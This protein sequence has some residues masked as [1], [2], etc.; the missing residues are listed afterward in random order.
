MRILLINNQHYLKGG[1]HAVYFNTAK[2]LR[3]KGHEV[4]F[5][6]MKDDNMIE[7]EYSS[8]FPKLIDYNKLSL[9]SKII[10]AKSFLYNKEA[11]CKIKNYVK[12]I[13]PDIAHVHLF[14]GGLTVSIL[15]ALKECNIPVIHTVHDYRLIC[16]AYTFLDRNNEICEKCHDGH[17]IR[18][19]YKKCSLEKKILPS[20]ILSFDAYFRKY[21]HSPLKYI[22]KF[23]F[24]SKFSKNIH[25]SFNKEYMKNSTVLYNFNPNKIG[26]SVPLK[27]KYLLY[28]GRLSREKGIEML[29]E[30]A[31]DLK[32][33]LKIAG[34]GPLYSK[35]LKSTEQNTNIEILGFKSGKD[36][37]QLIQG[38]SYVC[39]PSEWYENNPLSII[40][41]FSLGKPVIGSKIGGIPELLENKRGFLFNVKDYES[42]KNTINIALN[43]S[44]SE[45][46]KYSENVLNFAKNV[47]TKDYYYEKLTEIYNMVLE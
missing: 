22:D 41:S 45:Y 6:S 30:A 33:Q 21:F 32:A 16:P 38:C 25:I 1:A 27:G 10:A 14:M 24:V 19:A 15:R 3:E 43:I 2:L 4:Y 29:I 42:L 37:W 40:E 18:C 35:L 47:L 46:Q 36:L 9:F 8:Y 28:F 20:I 31:K 12:V 11:Y 5:F 34:I 44:D 13:K 23:I 17:F 39:V 26:N 7:Y